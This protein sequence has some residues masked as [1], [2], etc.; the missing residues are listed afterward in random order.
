M[1]TKQVMRY[2]L[3][4]VVVFLLALFQTTLIHSFKLFGVIPNLL[5]SS[6]VCYSLICGENK[7]MVFGIACGLIL[8]FYGARAVGINT[9]LCMLT[10]LGCILLHDGLFSNNA[11]V[12][13]LFVAVISVI[14]DLIIFF[15]YFVLWGQTDVL[16][17]LFR[18]ILPGAIYSGLVTI[19]IYPLM[20]A[21]ALEWAAPGHVKRW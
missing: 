8:D 20:R 9:L 10:A 16:Y 12:A 7:A 1:Q 2:V 15:F 11:F 5:L 21:V 17:A 19:F 3:T 6:V 4:G 13:M 14:Y 18:I